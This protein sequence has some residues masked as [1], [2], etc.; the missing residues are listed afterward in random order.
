MPAARRHRRRAR[1]STRPRARRSRRRRAKTSSPPHRSRRSLDHRRGRRLLQPLVLQEQNFLGLDVLRVQRNAADRT[2][3]HALRL[4]EVADA[5]G[6]AMRVD[7]VELRPHRDRLIRALGLAHIAVDAFVGD[8]QCHGGAPVLLG[9]GGQGCVD[10]RSCRRF[11]TEGATN[12]ETSPPRVAISRT[13]V[14]LMNWNWSLGARNSVST[15]GISWRFMP[16][17]GNSYAKSLA[18]RRPRTTTLPPFSTTKSPSRPRNG[19]HP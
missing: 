10:T 6:A 1:R 16:A 7:L 2:H 9:N 11:K 3:L 12:L 17:I 4:V 14:P 18:A 13:K 19:R 8:H 15:S 5:F